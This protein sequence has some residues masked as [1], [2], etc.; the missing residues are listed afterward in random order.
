MKPQMAADLTLLRSNVRQLPALLK[1]LGAALAERKVRHCQWKGHW[2]SDR[3]TT[4]EGDIDLLIA[5][6][7]FSAFAAVA[8][9]VGYRPTYTGPHAEIPGVSSWYGYDRELG[10]FLRLHV[11]TRLVLGVYWR[12]L[13]RLPLEVAALEE[14]VPRAV[15]PSPRP[16]IEL[17][18]FVLRMTLRH[19]RIDLRREPRWLTV[20]R[21]ELAYLEK[22]ANPERLYE[23]LARH[24]PAVDRGLFEQCRETLAQRAGWRRRAAARRALARALAAGA[25]PA[26]L[27]VIVRRA[28]AAVRA[29]V[30][31]PSAA[32]RLPASGGLLV[33]IVGADGAG[34][35]TCTL[36]L[37]K[38][39][40]A[41]FQTMHAHLGRPPR[42]WTTLLLGAVRKVL[43]LR[44]LNHL[45][46]LCTAR[47]RYRIAARTARFA[48]NGGIALC[49]RYPGAEHDQLVGPRIRATAGPNPGTLAQRLAT[50]EEDYY[51]RMQP[52]DLR[53]ILRV[54]PDVAVRR[55]TTEPADY[56]R[57]RA[58]AVWDA[59]WTGAN[60]RVIDAG[61]PLVDVV[62]DLKGALWLEL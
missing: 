58:M 55:K 19:S 36:A 45:R 12:T 57:R 28:V 9:E 54:P 56:V 62:A 48:L 4:G 41:H 61:Q 15:F 50:L 38:W 23:L 43:P 59:K 22:Q 31:A 30:R 52:P 25:R 17:I 46:Y 39:L 60:T 7:D 10:G 16:E 34:K 18:L 33:A 51:R 24:L 40:G 20:C 14:L 47:D 21:E 49:E 6:A 44:I 13:H 8:H 37:R 42:S 29:R 11:Y 2:K 32:A 5:P 27:S 35:S 3:W 26:T 53:L 1:Q